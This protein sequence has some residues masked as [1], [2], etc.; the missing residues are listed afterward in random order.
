MLWRWMESVIDARV[1]DPS[2]EEQHADMA[3][4]ALLRHSDSLGNVTAELKATL[5]RVNRLWTAVSDSPAVGEVM[6][7]LAD[8]E[9]DLEA[10]CFASCEVHRADERLPTDHYVCTCDLDDA[11]SPSPDMESGAGQG[12]QR[13]RYR[14]PKTGSVCV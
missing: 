14:P 8:I 9:G 3:V 4:E 12:G 13:L 10:F 1:P 2:L 7:N 11:P 5:R 6:Q